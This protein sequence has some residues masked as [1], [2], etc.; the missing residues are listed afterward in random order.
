VVALAIEWSTTKIANRASSRSSLF[1]PGI[2]QI[3]YSGSREVDRVVH[4]LDL[5]VSCSIP[6]AF[7]DSTFTARQ[8]H[9][10]GTGRHPQL[11]D[12]ARSI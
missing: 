9:G 8:R 5:R 6:A 2:F 4:E 1:L 12:A 7:T 3:S 11:R 10:A